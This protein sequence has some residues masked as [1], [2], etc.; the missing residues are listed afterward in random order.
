M[1]LFSPLIQV[2]AALLIFLI[3]FIAVFTSTLA[4]LGIA[5]L[6]C[7]GVMTMIKRVPLAA[8]S[9]ASLTHHIARPSQ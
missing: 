7:K 4:C 9:V 1:I 8:H 3:G 5:I 2:I 6:V